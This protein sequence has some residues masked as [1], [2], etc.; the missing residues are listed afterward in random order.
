MTA[1]LKQSVVGVG[2]M[3]EHTGKMTDILQATTFEKKIIL[4]RFF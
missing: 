2:T 3:C 4:A 1:I